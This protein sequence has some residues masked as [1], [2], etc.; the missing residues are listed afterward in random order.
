[1]DYVSVQVSVFVCALASGDLV[2]ARWYTLQSVQC[3][4]CA[5]VTARYVLSVRKVLQRCYISAQAL[6]V[7]VNIS[8]MCIYG[9][10]SVRAR[11]Q[12]GYMSNGELVIGA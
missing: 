12:C 7:G 2:R 5:L 10:L 1:M 4:E 3:R 9:W 11:A 6:L 8:V